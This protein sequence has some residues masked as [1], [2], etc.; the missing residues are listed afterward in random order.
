L[1]TFEGDV[2]YVG[3]SEELRRRFGD[4]R[5]N[6]EKCE[7]T[8]LGK[9]FW[10]YYLEQPETEINRLERSWLNQYAAVHCGYPVLN[11]VASPVR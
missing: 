3:L 4:H 9:A 5:G 8:A 1:T 6:D 10:F 7:V 2:L 11:R